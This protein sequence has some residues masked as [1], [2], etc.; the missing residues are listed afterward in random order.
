MKVTVPNS[1]KTE[2]NNLST[3]DCFIYPA[4]CKVYMTITAGGLLTNVCLHD[5]KCRK[6]SLSTLVEPVKHVSLDAE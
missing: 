6:I 4:D 2:L 1:T 5:G 3:G